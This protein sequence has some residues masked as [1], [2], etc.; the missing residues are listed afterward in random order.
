MEDRVLTSSSVVFDYLRRLP[1]SPWNR[2]IPVDERRTMMRR[3][4]G[5]ERGLAEIVG[6]L[7][8]VLIVVVAVTAFSLFVASYQA[9]LQAEQTAAH[10]RS[11][12]DIRILS[13]TTVLNTTNMGANYSSF[14]FV[15][16]SLDVNTMTI[17]ELT[18][19]GQLINFYT[20]TQLGSSA[21]LQ[22]CEICNRALPQFQNTVVEFNLTSLEQVTIT[23][24]LTTWSS[25]ALPH[26]GFLTFY[27]L[28]SFGPTNFISTSLYTTLG[29]DFDRVF[30]APTAL[31]LTEQSTIFSGGS[32]VPVVVF[33]AT[34]SIV[35]TNDTIVSWSWL[36][37]DQNN[38][39]WKLPGGG[40]ELLGEKAVVP[41]SAFTSGDYYTVVLAITS[42]VGLA[43]TATIQYV[44]S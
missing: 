24:N 28:A 19:N 1:Y 17:N 9:Q 14:S 8:L 21:V 10:N 34:D 23:V 5:H 40:N 30:D 37:T 26:G 20:V 35:A 13:V 44:A 6:T 43:G 22:I 15:A 32:D 41:Q 33:D 7:M 29:S 27:N 39:L 2:P 16:G 18:V 25:N 36:I 3:F 31:A 38:S 42:A 4:R 11:L 12:E